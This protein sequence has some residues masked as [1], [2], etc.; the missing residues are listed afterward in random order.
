MARLQEIAS[1]AQDLYFQDYPDR[2]AFFN[3]NAFKFHCAAKYSAMLNAMFQVWRKEGKQETGFSNVEINAQWLV[4]QK[5]DQILYDDAEMRYYVETEYPIFSFDFDAFGN[6]LNGI[7]PY[8]NNNCNL[9]KISNQEI[10]F[11]DVI[12]TTPDIYYYLEG[13]NRIYFLK[14][15][16]L[17]LTS[18]Y[19]PQVL[20]ADDNCVMSDNIVVDVIMATLQLMFGAKTGNVIPQ[21][22]DG[23]RNATLPQ[24]VNPDLGKG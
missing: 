16:T 9:K 12:P 3:L 24:Q 15:P 19:I 23:N 4:S 1:R 13:K 11:Y 5:I 2:K 21:A 10:R 17:P 14:K 20:G 8:G 6:G 7:R 22:D 18:Y